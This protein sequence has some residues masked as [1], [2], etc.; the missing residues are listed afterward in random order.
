MNKEIMK[1]AGF[2]EQVKDVEAGNCPFCHKKVDLAEFRDEVS[3]KE[4][5]IS[6]LC[7]KCQDSVFK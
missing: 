4:F 3:K 6:G 1:A 2:G 5:K 7:Q